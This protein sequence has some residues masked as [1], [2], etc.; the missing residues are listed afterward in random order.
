MQEAKK[1][2]SFFLFFLNV[3]TNSNKYRVYA[4]L[5]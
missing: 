3:P 1:H 5:V 4:E 2:D